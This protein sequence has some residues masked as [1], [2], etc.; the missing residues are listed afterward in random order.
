MNNKKALIAMSGGVD[1]S[2]AAHLMKQAGYDCIG[3]TMQL[4]DDAENSINDAK[5]V[6][7]CLDIPFYVFD[8]RKEFKNLVV[9]DFIASYENGETPNPCTVCNKHLKFG[10]LLEKAEELGCDILVTGHYAKIAQ[11][12]DV[13]VLKKA[14]DK[15]KDQSYFLYSLTPDILKKVK[16]PLGE[17]SKAEIRKIAEKM[18]IPTAK[19]KDSQ[20]ICFVP[21]GDYAKAISEV[22]KKVYPTGDFVDLNGNILGKHSGIINYTTGQRKGLGIALGKPAYVISKDVVNNQVVLG[23]N[24]DL[25]TTTL[26][27]RD[28]N[29]IYIKEDTTTFRCKARVRY[30]HEEQPATVKITGDTVTVI[31]DTPQRAITPG[32]SVV[33]YDDD[34]VLGGGII[35]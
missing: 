10:L 32:Q 24:D 27:A 14:E 18:N 33:L 26:K 17:Y 28:F 8:M 1:S 34:L 13:Y 15:N 23:S 12:N 20:D 4:L 31:F 22:T 35:E 11:E 21:D 3:A 30:R 25:F 29:P 19:R 6:A 5:R 9:D 16:F 2:V 7:T